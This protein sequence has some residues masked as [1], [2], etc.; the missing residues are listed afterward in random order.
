MVDAVLARTGVA[1]LDGSDDLGWARGSWGERSRD[2]GPKAVQ[3][4]RRVVMTG[5]SLPEGTRY[6]VEKEESRDASWQ[7]QTPS[8]RL[9]GLLE[10]RSGADANSKTL[11][12]PQSHVRHIQLFR[13]AWDV[14]VSAFGARQ[15]LYER[16]FFG[17]PVRMAGALLQS[18]DRTPYMDMVRDFLKRSVQEA[19]SAGS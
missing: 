9:S 4:S 6:Q 13:L 14:A 19:E 17:D 18:H 11:G 15:V 10:L 12:K 7:E 5:G 1:L 16:F 8:C 2:A 3:I